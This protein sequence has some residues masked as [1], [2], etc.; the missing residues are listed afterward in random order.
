MVHIVVDLGDLVQW[1]IQENL[2]LLRGEERHSKETHG[3]QSETYQFNEKNLDKFSQ[4]PKTR[5]RT[6]NT[7]NSRYIKKRECVSRTLQY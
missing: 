4:D 1:C 2:G 5:F 7:L 3:K 6:V